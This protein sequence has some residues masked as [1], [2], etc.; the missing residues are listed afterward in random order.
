[1]VA[2]SFVSAV[3][4]LV[5]KNKQNAKIRAKPVV[6]FFQDH[7]NINH[8]TG[9]A[10][11]TP[12]VGHTKFTFLLEQTQRAFVVLVFLLEADSS[13][14]GFCVAYLSQNKKVFMFDLPSVT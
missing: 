12:G 4:L 1:L 13:I 14:T 10:P 9:G 2:Y 5:H 8:T 11:N 3:C 7:G 6:G